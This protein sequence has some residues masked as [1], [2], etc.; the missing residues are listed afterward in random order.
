[1]RQG[2]GLLVGAVDERVDGLFGRCGGARRIVSKK[3]FVQILVIEGRGWL[4]RRAFETV[5]LRYAIG[6]ERR[7]QDRAASGPEAVTD[8]FVRIRLLHPSRPIARRRRL[9]G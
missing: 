5:R 7:F 4:Y 8:H 2:G 9:A 1:M 3:E 6:V